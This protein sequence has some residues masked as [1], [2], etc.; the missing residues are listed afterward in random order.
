MQ[1]HIIRYAV[2]SRS[3]IPT[4]CNFTKYNLSS[5]LISLR[6]PFNYRDRASR[7]DLAVLRCGLMFTPVGHKRPMAFLMFASL[8]SRST[9]I[10]GVS[11]ESSES[12]ESPTLGA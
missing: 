2:Y 8:R 1:L 3:C 7:E 9:I 11:S 5:I 6:S 4:V 10:R 12:S